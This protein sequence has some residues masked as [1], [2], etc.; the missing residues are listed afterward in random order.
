M[1]LATVVAGLVPRAPK[2]KSPAFP[3]VV[4][5]KALIMDLRKTR[6][7]DHKRGLLRF[8]GSRPPQKWNN[9]AGTPFFIF[10]KE[11]PC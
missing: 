11:N 4:R 9:I 3:E 1:I 6:F 7:R 2:G 8:S 5:R 10:P